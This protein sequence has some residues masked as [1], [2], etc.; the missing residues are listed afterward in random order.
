MRSQVPVSTMTDMNRLELNL[1]VANYLEIDTGN[2]KLENVVSGFWRLYVHSAPGAFLT[3]G[4]QR[5]PIL[6]G[7]VYL[8]PSGVRF[9]SETQSVV[10]HF[11]IHFELLGLYSLIM[12]EWFTEIVHLPKPLPLGEWLEEV[13]RRHVDGAPANIVAEIEMRAVLYA[14]LGQ[15]LQSLSTQRIEDALRFAASVEPVM[16]AVRYIESHLAE[17][18]SNVVL[19][20]QCFMSEG[21]FIRRFQACVGQ[22][23]I[24]FV[25]SRRVQQAAHQ[26]LHTDRSLAMIATDAGFGSQPYFNRIF[27]RIMGMSPAKYRRTRRMSAS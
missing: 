16:P 10:G 7:D 24:Q 26:L 22:S 5:I 2:W 15:Y 21:H 4:S 17:P 13:I 3:S 27:T 6:P 25:Q 23:P 19:A 11:Y 12:R 18:L 14:M 8:I 20:A 9:S 1:L